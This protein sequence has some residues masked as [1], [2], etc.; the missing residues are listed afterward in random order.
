MYKKLIAGE[1]GLKETFWKFGIFGI[2][3]GLLIVKM[4][5]ALL[6]PLLGGISIY[7][8]FT[9]YFNPLK[10]DTSIVVYTVCYL[11]SLCLFIAY[12]ISMVFAVWRSGARYERSP[13]LSRIARLVIIL[14]VYLC[15]RSFF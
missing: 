13:W 9:A 10:M 15:L 14:V 1:F 7:K 11:T 12:N 5:G 6:A 3:A 4:F 8:Y 2:L